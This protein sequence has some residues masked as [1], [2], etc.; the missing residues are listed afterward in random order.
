[1]APPS[2]ISEES[3]VI[4]P[5][6]EAETLRD[7][8]AALGNQIAVT[9]P[10]ESTALCTEMA[11]L[12]D[13]LHQVSTKIKLEGAVPKGPEADVKHETFL[14]ERVA[15]LSSGLAGKPL[16]EL[17]L[18]SAEITSCLIELS[19]LQM[20]MGKITLEAGYENMKAETN[21]EYDTEWEELG[22]QRQGFSRV[23][24]D[25]TL[26]DSEM[27]TEDQGTRKLRDAFTDDRANLTLDQLRDMR[28]AG[29]TDWNDIEE[30]EPEGGVFGRKLKS[31]GLELESTKPGN[32]DSK[33]ASVPATSI[34]KKNG[35]SQTGS[36]T[37][38]VASALLGLNPSTTSTP[39]VDQPTSK[40]E[41]LLELLKTPEGRKRVRENALKGDMQSVLALSQHKSQSIQDALVEMKKSA[42]QMATEHNKLKDTVDQL[43]KEL[44][45]A[46]QTSSTQAE[47]KPKAEP[48]AKPKTKE[49]T[50][51]EQ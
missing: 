10:S 44:K 9:L 13:Q 24:R 2:Q 3:G 31:K 46:R 5:S 38:V 35:G 42:K 49:P 51:E 21:Q 48:K 6:K 40:Q 34:L 19:E 33:S 45:A 15:R 41:S 25:Q 17:Y 26:H 12:S 37:T 18:D 20:K 27:R 1:L 32:N 50:S 39:A 29:V 36:E 4:N 8:I 43:R 28:N 16:N 47:A 23:K 7:R 14:K 11:R 22:K 30:F